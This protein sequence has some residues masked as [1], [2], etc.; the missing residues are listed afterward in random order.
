MKTA[1]PTPVQLG[2]PLETMPPS[3]RAPTSGHEQW[4]LLA[5]VIVMRL[6]SERGS[7]GF[8]TDDC[9]GRLDA[10]I[11]HVE[12]SNRQALG[13]LLTRLKNAGLIV[14]TARR[15]IDRRRCEV[16]VWMAADTPAAA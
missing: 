5:E 10:Q 12:P 8:I 2:F 7:R 13:G 14:K 3:E 4:L 16:P 15:Q 6:A 9:W 1:T 11:V